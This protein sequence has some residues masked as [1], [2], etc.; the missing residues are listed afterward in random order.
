[1]PWHDYDMMGKFSD[2][3][4]YYKKAIDIDSEFSD[5][6]NSLGTIYMKQKNGRKH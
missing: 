4:T 5:A 3:E 6:Y 1:M 2:A